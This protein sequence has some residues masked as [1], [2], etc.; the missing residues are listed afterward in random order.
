ML[1]T[2]VILDFISGGILYYGHLCMRGKKS[3]CDTDLWEGT[4]KAAEGHLAYLLFKKAKEEGLNI[5]LNWQDQDSTAEKSFRSIFPDGELNRVMLCGGHVGRSHGNNLKEYKGK[6]VVD[7]GFIDKHKKNRPEISKA[8]CC[9]EGKKHSKSCGCLSD[10]FIAA[11]KRNHF[12]AL[13]QSHNSSEEYSRRMIALGRYHCR[14]IHQWINKD[15]ENEECGFHALVICS[16]GSCVSN[17][18]DGNDSNDAG[19]SDDDDGSGGDHNVSN[20]DGDSNDESDDNGDINDESDDDESDDDD[21]NDDG[22][23]NEDSDYDDIDNSDEDEDPQLKC[24]GKSYTTRKILHCELHALLYEIECTRISQKA[25]DIV[26]EEM[27]RGHSSMP[28]SKFN[29][30][31]RFHTKNVNLHQLHYEFITNVGLC[32][33][34]M[35]FMYKEYGPSYH[36]MK[37]LYDL[38]HLPTPDGLEEIWRME[39]ERRMKGLIKKRTDAAKS[40]RAKKKQQRLQESKQRKKFVQRQKI[41]HNYGDQG[42]DF[43]EEELLQEVQKKIRKNTGTREQPKATD[44]PRGARVNIGGQQCR[45]GSKEHL[46]IS[47]RTCPLNKNKNS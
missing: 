25:K 33:S 38:L 3:V 14:D 28:E 31:T 1:Y 21:S 36:W 46:R 45:C 43:G 2:F 39:N 18:S 17:G 6:K 23:D 35:T 8:K 29:V 5:A 34:N 27:G 44:A 26:H 11:A 30:L 16:C 40:A 47:H 9:C 15:G 22:S 42:E 19:S 20:G 41:V 13:K 12:S 4:S 24:P 10:D 32:Q 7:K 37:E